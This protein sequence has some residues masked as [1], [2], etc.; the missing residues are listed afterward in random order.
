MASAK[1][2]RSPK[3][4]A[5]AAISKDDIAAMIAQSDPQPL[6]RILYLTGEVNEQS[7]NT[8]ISEI[9][10]CVNQNKLEPITI[11]I[12]TYGGS[13]DE[14]FALYDIMKFVPCPI[15]TVGLGKIMSAGVLLLTS[16]VKG[17]RLIGKHARIMVHPMS[18]ELHG[19]VFQIQN[20]LKETER[21]QKSLENA[22]LAETKMTSKQLE[23]IMRAGHD[24]YITPEE[25]VKLGLVDRIIG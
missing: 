7:I 10:L 13:V 3:K 5:K 9:I 1:K 17:S 8:L 25:A 14:M 11:V 4:S 19:D 20:D 24:A 16:G 21:M 18:D 15:Y 2:P 22:L 23:T 6:G 12:S